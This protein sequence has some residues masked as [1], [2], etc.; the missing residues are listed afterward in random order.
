MKDE[1]EDEIPLE[2]DFSH[3][4][5]GKYAGR[6]WHDAVY[7]PLEADVSDAFRTPEEVNSALRMLIKT[8]TAAVPRAD[9]KAS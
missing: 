8:A 7:V 6:V 2:V 1:L 5:R 9:R 4:V 3:G